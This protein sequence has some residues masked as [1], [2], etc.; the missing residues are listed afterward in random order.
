MAS[1]KHRRQRLQEAGY[2]PKELQEE[3]QRGWQAG[4]E[5]FLESAYAATC[6][7]LKE[8]H[9]FGRE[10]CKKVLQSMDQHVLFTLS[11]VEIVEEVWERLGLRLVFDKPF[12]RIEEE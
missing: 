7:A 5:A 10:R 6:L 12:D 9:G 11:S 2:T 3:Y 1:R 8:T 4:A